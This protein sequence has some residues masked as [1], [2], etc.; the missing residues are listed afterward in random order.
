MGSSCCFAQH[1]DHIWMFG[2][3]PYDALQEEVREDS[4]WGSTNIDFNYSPPKIYYDHERL[5]D[6]NATNVSISNEEGKILF[7]SNGQ[8]IWGGENEFIEDTINYN[9]QWENW[10]LYEDGILVL[11][12][13]PAI[14]GMLAL[15]MPEQDSV[16]MLIYSQFNLEMLRTMNLFYSKIDL[17]KSVGQQLV[18]RDRFLIE[19]DTIASGTLNAVRHS[20]GRDW[21]V[22]KLDRSNANIYTFLLTPSGFI[23]YDI[24]AFGDDF[25]TSIG[26]LVFSS[27]GTKI[28]ANCNPR[29]SSD[30]SQIVIADFDR[31]TGEISNIQE[32]LMSRNTYARGLAFSP[33]SR[34]LY[35]SDGLN[36]H[37]YDFLEEDVTASRVEV[38]SYD[39]FNYYYTEDSLFPEPQQFGWMGL[40]PNGKI[41]ISTQMGTSRVMH[42][43]NNP[44][45]K[46]EA[47]DID[48][49]SI[50]LP[51]SYARGIPNFPNYRL[52]PLDDSFAD[53]LGLDNH[54]VAKFR[55][56][57]DSLEHMRVHFLDL[58]YFDPVD[59]EWDFG[60]GNFSNELEPNHTYT[61]QGVY[62]VCLT[63]S[64]I[65][66]SSTNC[67]TIIIGTTSTQNQLKE[68]DI[69]IFPNPTF[70][71][72]TLSFHNYLAIDAE[73]W[74][75]NEG[76]HCISKHVLE[77]AR[78]TLDLRDLAAGTYIYRV[79]DEGLQVSTGR[80]IKMR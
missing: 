39:G 64:N 10:T 30:D 52:G 2:Y 9:D 6:L 14:Q 42:Q 35:V 4:T 48:Q 19:N 77:R 34:F 71:F 36:V 8:A 20:N 46:G 74:I 22:L 3:S 15:P 78:I 38:E 18:E 63:V 55:Y 70:D 73:V 21:W 37:Q 24:S 62:E 25:E 59:Y 54:P 17:N 79:I 26:Q 69:S 66:N 11:E 13:L 60:D 32:E 27:D 53:T 56:V 75:Y 28:A 12:G 29:L 1:E 76:G 31:S 7:Y 47:C 65:Y 80:F 61:E 43:I 57:Q 49:H 51:T 45:L 58:S 5:I 23:T 44:N 50:F 16:Y 67:K 72:I 33:N 40:A 41:Y 68:V